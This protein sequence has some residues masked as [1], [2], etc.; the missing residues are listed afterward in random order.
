VASAV[1]PQTYAQAQASDA[2]SGSSQ[3]LSEVVLSKDPLIAGMQM[4]RA[5]F[6]LASDEQTTRSRAE[7]VQVGE[8]IFFSGTPVVS[9]EY[10]QIQRQLDDERTASAVA[11]E[12]IGLSGFAGA[13]IVKDPAVSLS[14]AF[15]GGR[16]PDTAE[17]VLRKLG[18]VPYE[19]HARERSMKDVEAAYELASRALIDQEVPVDFA[20]DVQSGSIRVQGF[21]EGLTVATRVLDSLGLSVPIIYD[22]GTPSAPEQVH[23]LFGGLRTA[24][25]GSNLWGCTLGLPFVTT[26]GNHPRPTTAGHCTYQTHY[27]ATDPVALRIAGA[28]S[29]A[30]DTSVLGTSQ[31]GVLS[32]DILTYANYQISGSVDLWAKSGPVAVGGTVCDSQGSS[33]QTR[34][35]SV[36]HTNSGYGNN[37]GMYRVKMCSQG[38]DS[39]SAAYFPVGAGSWG[40]GNHSGGTDN[41]ADCNTTDNVYI[42]KADNIEAAWQLTLFVN[43]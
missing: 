37:S 15:V 16:V 10:E 8:A 33:A 2:V 38:G 32:D 14:V 4:N 6:G 41:G 21:E 28:D 24:S 11:A 40:V 3:A 17:A 25:N 43:G 18:I 12:L 39:G 19:L 36:A 35:G 30:L 23:I 27:R 29:G 20:L 31:F 26:V 9:E 22:L 42:G 7:L 1:P 34:C 13:W 5:T